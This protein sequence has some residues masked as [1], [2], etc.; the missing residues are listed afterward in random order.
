MVLLAEN[1]GLPTFFLSL[2]S[3]SPKH[4]LDRLQKVKK[5]TLLGSTTGLPNS[6]M[7]RLFSI[8]YT[9]SQ[10][11]KGLISN[12]L[13]FA[14]NFWMVLPLPTSQI[15]FTFT[16][17]HGSSVLLQTPEFSEYPPFAQSQLPALFLLPSSNKT[18]QAPRFYPSRITLKTF[19]FSKTFSSVPL[20]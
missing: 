10:L 14:L 2:C 16:S 19:L 20:P 6:I 1:P 18:E 15:F 3:G 11:K 17:L 5:T 7:S 4:L 12:S 8:L 9:G 13:H